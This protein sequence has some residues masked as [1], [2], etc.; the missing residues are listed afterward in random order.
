VGLWRIKLK[1]ERAMGKISDALEKHGSEREQN[2]V[3]IQSET[4]IIPKLSPL[5]PER[6]SRKPVKSDL[7]GYEDIL[8]R[9]RTQHPGESIKTI[10]FTGATHGG[11]ATTTAVNFAKALVR[12]HKVK[13]LLIDANMRTPNLKELFDIENEGGLT[14]IVLNNHMKPFKVINFDPSYLFVLATGGNYVGPVGLFES[15]RFD[16]FLKNAR[17]EFDYIILDSAPLPSF[18]E[19]RVLCEKVDGVI[20]V[21]ESGKIRRQVALRAKKELE[22]AGAQILGVVLN[23]RKYH[24]PEWLYKRL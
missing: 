22:D 12:D 4:A 11:G 14:D 8:T 9:L 24:I 2:R 17:E 15:E 20:L 13:V 5:P 10:M 6:K 16:T 18:A 23:K 3:E 21:F 1:K 19:A 7:A